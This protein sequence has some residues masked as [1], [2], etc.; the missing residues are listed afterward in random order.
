M[1]RRAFTLM[2]LLVVISI[3]MI[4]AGMLVPAANRALNQAR[5]TSCGSQLRQIGTAV[6][7]YGVNHAEYLPG[8]ADSYGYQFFGRFKGATE[9]VDFT[10]GYLSEY[11]NS[12]RD[13]WQCPSTSE[14]DFM[15]RAMGPCTGYGYNYYYLTELKEKGNWWDPDY[16]YSWQGLPESVIRDYTTTLVFA[17]SARDW[18]GPIEEN[19]FLDPTSQCLAWPGW[20]SL[21]VHFRHSLRCNVLWADGHVTS[22]PPDKDTWP[23]NAHNLGV[24]CDKTDTYFKPEK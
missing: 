2:E 3:I 15:P 13:I 14:D 5:A 23:V 9:E 7:M 17:D 10:L 22:E 20:E 18:M 16:Q 24:L 4:L 6:Q 12:E 21:Y 19:W 1:R 11:V 8:C